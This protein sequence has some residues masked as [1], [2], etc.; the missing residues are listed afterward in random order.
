VERETR[1]NIDESRVIFWFLMSRLNFQNDVFSVLVFLYLKNNIYIYI[2]IYIYII[3]AVIT[4][5]RLSRAVSGYQFVGGFN[6]FAVIR[7]AVSG[8]LFSPLLELFVK[9]GFSFFI[10]FFFFLNITFITD[11]SPKM[12]LQV[13]T[14]DQRSTQIQEKNRG[15]IYHPKSGSS[16]CRPWQ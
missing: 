4:A 5:N 7:L 10:F 11:K 15:R 13:I 3:K 14:R 1:Q 2:Y 8:R 9:S 16:A 12:G 6:G